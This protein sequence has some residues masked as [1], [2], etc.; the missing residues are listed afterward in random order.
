[1]YFKHPYTL[2]A[3]AALIKRAGCTEILRIDS[4]T[5]WSDEVTVPAEHLKAAKKILKKKAFVDVVT[6]Q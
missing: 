1:M 5:Q 4:I 6:A 2:E 3:R